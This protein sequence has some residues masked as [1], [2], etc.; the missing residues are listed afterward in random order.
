M[1]KSVGTQAPRYELHCKSYLPTNSGV[2]TGKEAD[3]AMNKIGVAMSDLAHQ[4]I[5]AVDAL[6]EYI[7]S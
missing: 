3:M 2:I 6:D 7:S 1:P 5:A 4:A